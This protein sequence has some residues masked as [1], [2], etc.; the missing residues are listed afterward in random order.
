MK[1]YIKRCLR[2]AYHLIPSWLQ[3]LAYTLLSFV[4]CPAK[5]PR[6]LAY[7]LY[8]YKLSKTKFTGLHLG[9]GGAR[10]K[11][12]LNIDANPSVASDVVA[13]IEKLKVDSCSVGIIYTSHVFEHLPR[14]RAQ[15][16]LAEWYRA[17][18]QGGVLY[19]CVPDVETLFKIYLDNL[20][21]YG[22]ADARSV[23]DLAC[24]VIYGGQ[25]NKYDFHYFGYSF[26]TLKYMLENVGF[27]GVH[28]FDRASFELFPKRD[29]AFAAICDV[30]VS[31]N[32]VA[33]K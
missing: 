31:L 21:N 3:P 24:G 11:S 25:T 23:A 22:V 13:G 12:F 20:P 10:I 26:T 30:P 5:F 8:V 27:Q 32:V 14:A 6:S 17:L 7:H 2:G 33:T 1:S 9:A 16:V 28:R 18:K 15:V 19:I 4:V 29:A